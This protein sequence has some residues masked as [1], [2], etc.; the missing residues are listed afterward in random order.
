MIA[1][2]V[3]TNVLAS[4]ERT[5]AEEELGMAIAMVEEH[6]SR[7]DQTSSKTISVVPF[8]ASTT[9]SSILPRSSIVGSSS[10]IAMMDNVRHKTCRGSICVNVGNRIKLF[11]P[12]FMY[13]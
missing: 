5:T 8:S 3:D 6:Q 2:G 1:A 9:T 12:L 10:V 11:Q 7:F 13:H 4:A